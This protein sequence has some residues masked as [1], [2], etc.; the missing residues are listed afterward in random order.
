MANYYI[1]QLPDDLAKVVLAERY[2]DSLSY[3]VIHDTEGTYISAYD[4]K[5][6]ERV[7]L[8][9]RGDG[10]PDD[11]ELNLVEEEIVED[12]I[13]KVEDETYAGWHLGLWQ[14]LIILCS[15]VLIVSCGFAIWLLLR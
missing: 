5:T 8:S 15:L 4:K 9:E 14:V 11:L 7:S 10:I 3:R 12:A 13:D 1:E 6:G 2:K